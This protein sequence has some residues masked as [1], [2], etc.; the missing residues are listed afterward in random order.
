MYIISAADEYKLFTRYSTRNL[1]NDENYNH[2]VKT[3][4]IKKHPLVLFN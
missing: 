1:I 2:A 3:L 4:W